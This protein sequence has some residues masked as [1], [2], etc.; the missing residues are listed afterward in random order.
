V[1]KMISEVYRVLKPKGVYICICHGQ[2]ETRLA[3]FENVQSFLISRP[4]IGR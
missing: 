1:N 4:I 3:Q 2:P